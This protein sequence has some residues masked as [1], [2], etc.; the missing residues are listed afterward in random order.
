MV[1]LPE[2]IYLIQCYGTG[3]LKSRSFNMKFPNTVLDKSTV[4]RLISKF[5]AT[6]SVLNI[7]KKE[8]LNET[9]RNEKVM[10]CGL[11]VDTENCFLAASPDGLVQD[12]GLI[13]VKCPSTA[14]KLTPEEAIRQKKIHL[15][16]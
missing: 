16:Q 7:Q 4:L 10:L 15:L 9:T 13:E 5:L 12:D 11:F 2:R 1:T 6:G 14:E 8:E 3:G